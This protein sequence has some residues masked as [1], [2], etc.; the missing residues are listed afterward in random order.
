MPDVNISGLLLTIKPSKSLKEM[1]IIAH[2]LALGASL[3]SGLPIA[4][5]IGLFAIICLHLWLT[6]RHLN[7]EHYTVSI[8]MHLAGKYLKS[9]ALPRLRF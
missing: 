8:L 5:K 9:V 3:A 7:T 6:I 4:F 2:T 1:I